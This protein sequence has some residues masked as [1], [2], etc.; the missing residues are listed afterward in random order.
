M[1][2]IQFTAANG[3]P[4]STYSHVLGCIKQLNPN[5]QSINAVDKIGHTDFTIGLSC[6]ALVDELILSIV[7]SNHYPVIGIGHSIGAMLTLQAAA[8]RPDLF[9]SLILLEPVIYRRKFRWTTMLLFKL[10]RLVEIHF[11]VKSAKHRKV[12][13]SSRED[14]KT[15][16]S[17]KTI[18]SNFHPDSLE[19]Y[20]QYGLEPVKGEFRLSFSR[21][22]E[23]KIL[24]TFPIP[25]RAPKLKK[26]LEITICYG[27]DSEHLLHVDFEWW[28]KAYRNVVDVMT[29]GGHL[30]PFEHPKVTADMISRIL[31]GEFCEKENVFVGTSNREKIKQLRKEEVLLTST[32][33]NKGTE[34][35]FKWLEDPEKYVQWFSWLNSYKIIYQ[36]KEKVGNI[37]EY[38]QTGHGGHSKVTSLITDYEKG[39]RIA[40]KFENKKFTF[41]KEYKLK[42][43]G[44]QTH[45]VLNTRIRFHGFNRIFFALIKNFF[46]KYE[47]Q[48]SVKLIGQLKQKCEYGTE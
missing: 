45:L 5:I 26:D 37:T 6:N 29:M 4:A 19:N 44:E 28:R 38:I 1:P 40:Y 43:L 22:I 32:I 14:A 35:I 2:H 42:D 16:F 23:A 7:N 13:F 33:I 41:E 8:K 36:S 17:R 21:I 25:L 27:E 39:K 9:S 18:F 24:K 11:V 12:N 20:V 47:N 15:Y 30:F 31:K 48:M 10:A 46:N 3:F 34:E